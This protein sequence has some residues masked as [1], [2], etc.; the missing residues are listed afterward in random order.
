[1]VSSIVMLLPYFLPALEKVWLV[2][3]AVGY[4]SAS[5]MMIIALS[6]APRVTAFAKWLLIGVLCL[7]VVQYV[8]GFFM[9][10]INPIQL[11]LPLG[12][13]IV[14]FRSAAQPVYEWQDGVFWKDR[15]L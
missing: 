12:T 4:L 1:M 2:W 8:I 6:I 10:P 15:S 5:T 3:L 9:G 13:A 14:I 11:Y 7:Y